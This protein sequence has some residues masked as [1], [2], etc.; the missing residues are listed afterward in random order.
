M[1]TGNRH[2]KSRQCPGKR[3]GFFQI[4]NPTSMEACTMSL[5]ANAGSVNTETGDFSTNFSNCN[6]HIDARQYVSEVA[7]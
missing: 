1:R 2:E 5:Q 7:L 4:F 3:D 6:T